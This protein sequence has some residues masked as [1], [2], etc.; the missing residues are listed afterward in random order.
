MGLHAL[1]A[2]LLAKAHSLAPEDPLRTVAEAT[3]PRRLSSVTGWRELGR[4]M[5]GRAGLVPPPPH[6]AAS[7]YGSAAVDGRGRSLHPTGHRTAADR[8]HRGGKERRRAAPGITS[9]VRDLAVVRRIGH[10]WSPG[11]RSR[12]AGGV[13]GRQSPGAQGGSGQA[14]LQLPRGDGRAKSGHQAPPGQPGPHRAPG[15]SASCKEF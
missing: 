15:G 3:A 7:R 13:P 10:R 6:R 14:V 12:R 8:C 1:A 9:P 2:R 5:W 11:R 4:Q